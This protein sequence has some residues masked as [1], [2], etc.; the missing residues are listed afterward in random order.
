MRGAEGEAV[1]VLAMPGELVAGEAVVQAAAEGLDVEG[2]SAERPMLYDLLLTLRNAEGEVLAVYPSRIGF[3]RSEVRGGQLRVNGQAVEIR[4]VN[5][6]DHDP[7]TGHAISEEAMRRDLVLMKRSNINAVRSSHYPNAPRFY[8]LCDEL[9]LYVACEANLESHGMGTKKAP[10]AKD[11]SWEAA[12]VDRVRNMVEAFRNHPSIILWSLGNEAGDGPN[13]VAA[14]DWIRANDPSR[15]V[16]YEGAARGADHVTLFTP[17]HAR[18]HEILAYCREEEKKPLAEQRPLVLCE[19]N[20]AMGNSSGGLAVYG[21]VFE[22]ERL[23]QGGFLWD[24]ADQTLW[25]EGVTTDGGPARFHAYGGDVGGVPNSRNFCANGIFTADRKPTPQV[26]EVK[27]VFQPVGFE[28]VGIDGGTA[29][30]RVHNRRF[31]EPLDDVRLEWEEL[32][33]EEVVGYG[34]GPPPGT[35]PR[36]ASEVRLGF[37]HG[38]AEK[39]GERVLTVRAVLGEDAAWADPGHE[40]AWEQSTVPGG[41]AHGQEARGALGQPPEVRRGERADGP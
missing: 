22:R 30:V 20:H 23:A 17:M 12:H 25:K 21:E 40:V 32:V 5:R 39:P 16:Q 36:G 38:A 9:G 6:H 15:P 37:L 4:G 41:L 18:P 27:K 10:L 11:P 14:S 3:R 33:D 35:P 19:F 8:E 2:W 1:A 34:G 13:L 28:L 31:F 26:A 29:T 7:A 24:F